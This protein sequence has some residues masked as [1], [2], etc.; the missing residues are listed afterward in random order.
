M[1][2]LNEIII[3]AIVSLISGGGLMTIIKIF[4]DHSQSKQKAL[5][6]NIDDRIAAWQKISEKNESK[7]EQLERKIE[8]QERDIRSLEKYIQ[9][10]ELIIMRT[11]PTLSLPERPVLEREKVI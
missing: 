10:L 1:A 5:D 8:S 11:A 4:I 3:T 2:N 9:S 6:K 7:L